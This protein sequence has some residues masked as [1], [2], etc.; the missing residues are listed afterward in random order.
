MI[1]TTVLKLHF[2][3]PEPKLNNLKAMHLEQKNMQYKN[4]IYLSNSQ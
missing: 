4:K 3:I 1:V 2:D